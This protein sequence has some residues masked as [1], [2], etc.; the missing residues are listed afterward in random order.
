MDQGMV[1]GVQDMGVGVEVEP[2]PSYWLQPQHA[3]WPGL[4]ELRKQLSRGPLEHSQ[5]PSA[6]AHAAVELKHVTLLQ[7]AGA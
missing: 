7:C 4:P 5:E 3:A 1:V 2:D 6:S